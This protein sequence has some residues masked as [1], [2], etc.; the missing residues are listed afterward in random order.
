VL[1]SSTSPRRLR[2][3]YPLSPKRNSL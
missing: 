3:R 1:T 2:S